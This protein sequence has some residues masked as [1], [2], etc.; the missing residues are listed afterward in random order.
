MFFRYL[1]TVALI[2]LNKTENRKED[3]SLK[4]L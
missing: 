4:I 1:K 2:I 3:R